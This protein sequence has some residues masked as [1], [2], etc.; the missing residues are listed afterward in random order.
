MWTVCYT[1]GA[2][3]ESSFGNATE[4]LQIYYQAMGDCVAGAEGGGK[5]RMG[6][7]EMCV[8][9]ECLSYQT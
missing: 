5:R 2:H 3:I 9:E 8:L 1:K 6:G 7:E 4:V